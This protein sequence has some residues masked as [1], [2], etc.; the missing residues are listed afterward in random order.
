MNA[1]LSTV[2]ALIGDPARARML[3]SLMGNNPLRAGELATI[4]NVA[5]A[6]AS[7][8]LA[9]LLDGRLLS[10]E[11]QGRQRYYTL[12]DEQV[13]NAI[14]ALLAVAGDSQLRNKRENTPQ[15]KPGTLAHARTCYAHLAGW[16][17]VRIADALEERGFIAPLDAKAYMITSSGRAWFEHLAIDLPSAEY[18]RERPV[19]RRCLDWTERRHHL[20]GP[21]GRALNKRLNELRWIAPLRGTRAVRVTLQG[22]TRLWELLR[23]PT[24]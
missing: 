17:G 23:I 13:A 4:A 6:T 24:A 7:G 18:E 2:A 20:G 14:E 1:D 21:A 19:A 11:R 22:K 5:P 3:L 9:K 15:A 10:A 8:H 16:L 12:F